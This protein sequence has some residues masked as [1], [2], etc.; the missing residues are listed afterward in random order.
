M[1]SPYAK[2]FSWKKNQNSPDFEDLK[3]KIVRFL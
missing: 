1:I 3:K 2:D